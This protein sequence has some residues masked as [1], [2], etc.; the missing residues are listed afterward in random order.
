MALWDRARPK[1]VNS[2][3]PAAAPSAAKSKTRLKAMELPLSD[4][5]KRVEYRYPPENSPNRIYDKDGVEMRACVVKVRKDGTAS[6][7][8]EDGERGPI[9]IHW[10]P[11]A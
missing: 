4:Y 3:S 10:M 5:G 11:D 1:A 9:D 7:E 8:Y 2:P 6:I